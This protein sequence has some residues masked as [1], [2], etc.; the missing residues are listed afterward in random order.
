MADI[1]WKFYLVFVVYDKTKAKCHCPTLLE[2]INSM[3]G[4]TVVV[5]WTDATAAG[6]AQIDGVITEKTRGE[7]LDTVEA[8]ELQWSKER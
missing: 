8:N 5:I 7:H 6:K 4:E 3:L 1:G 2:K